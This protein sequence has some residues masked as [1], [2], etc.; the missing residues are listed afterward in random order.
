M[1]PAAAIA[2]SMSSYMQ[3]SGFDLSQVIE[4]R[5]L[6]MLGDTNT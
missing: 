5:L 2:D 4:L 1:I 6:Q 3:I